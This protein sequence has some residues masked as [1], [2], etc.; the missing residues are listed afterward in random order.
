L[1][2]DKFA[3]LPFFELQR[4]PHKA[5][6]RFVKGSIQIG[7]EKRSSDARGSL[8]IGK[9]FGVDDSPVENCDMT[10]TNNFQ[11]NNCIVEEPRPVRDKTFVTVDFSFKTS[12]VQL[13]NISSESSLADPSLVWSL[14]LL[15]NG[16]VWYE[17]NG[18]VSQLSS[19]S[20]SKSDLLISWNS[21]STKESYFL[22]FPEHLTLEENFLEILLLAK[23]D[24]LSS[25][26]SPSNS[27][28]LRNSEVAS[29][30]I[31]TGDQLLSF[32]NETSTVKLLLNYPMI[33]RPNSPSSAIFSSLMV[34]CVKR[35]IKSITHRTVSTISLRPA[36]F[37][38][39][40]IST[41]LKEEDKNWNFY[42]EEP[43]SFTNANRNVSEIDMVNFIDEGS[44]FLFP[45]RQSLFRTLARRTDDFKSADLCKTEHAAMDFTLTIKSR[46]EEEH[47]VYWRGK[48]LPKN[49]IFTNE[50]A[51][52]S[53][54]SSRSSRLLRTKSIHDMEVMA[55]V[56]YL[57][58][59]GDSV[60]SN[61]DLPMCVR[62]IVSTGP[63]LISRIFRLEL[64]TNSQ[65]LLGVSDI[66][67]E[68]EDILSC[69]G[70]ENSSLYRR[71]QNQ[72][73]DDWD[74]QTLFEFIVKERLIFNFMSSERRN[75]S[76]T[77]RREGLLQASTDP[78]EVQSGSIITII[79]SNKHNHCS[80]VEILA[81][82]AVN[83]EQISLI[84]AS[85]GCSSNH[86]S[87][88]D[89]HALFLSPSFASDAHLFNVIY[90]SSRLVQIFKQNKVRMFSRYQRI[91]GISFRCVIFLSGVHETFVTRYKQPNGLDSYFRLY[92]NFD[93]LKE[94]IIFIVCV[95]SKTKKVYELSLLGK[96][97][98]D[99]TLRE[100]QYS[101]LGSRFRRN[102]FG[103]LLT[104]YV[105]LTF[106]P[107][108]DF[109]LHFLN[110]SVP[111]FDSTAHDS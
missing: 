28:F 48:I 55:D 47:R 2:T 61:D 4:N 45:S 109:S 40:S 54:L 110:G 34:Y 38:F 95:D 14:L 67:D 70:V 17:I 51:K 33:T 76:T 103:I 30:I 96:H 43:I 15:L 58:D 9:T 24:D 57:V 35:E 26:S 85:N 73:K 77:N 86:T 68:R 92:D 108:E 80:P 37:Q 106:L 32:L 3:F 100:F 18:K 19:D 78:S 104:S 83:Q 53:I 72:S 52:Q 65:I 63:G 66:E 46:F 59:F 79:R 62:E 42:F 29:G 71:L 49:T 36:F 102:K 7:L 6:N 10:E 23:K 20:K 39:P 64:L 81:T 50:K 11:G 94:L 69:I 101:N 41:N 87:S 8:L 22:S 105:S 12:S 1:K 93:G 84:S 98:I 31:L 107:S 88:K 27:F 99:W 74:Y 21:D 25:S 16:E 82:A 60:I 56:H 75:A 97:L 90:G 5:D 111:A 91:T 44:P 13:I 89:L